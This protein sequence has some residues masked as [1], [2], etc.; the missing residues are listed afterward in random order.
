L[1]LRKN[2]SVSDVLGLI[3]KDFR[4]N[5]KFARIFNSDKHSGQKVGLDYKLADGDVIEIH[6]S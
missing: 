1:G 2:A 4:K 3:H 6:T 5:F